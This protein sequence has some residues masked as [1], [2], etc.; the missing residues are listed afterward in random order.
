MQV[1]SCRCP[2]GLL[3][4]ASSAA[5]LGCKLVARSGRGGR[6]E[7]NTGTPPPPPPFLMAH[8]GESRMV[9]SPV[10][11]RAAQ[12]HRPVAAP[13]SVFNLE[14]PI[15]RGEAA[16]SISRGRGR[17]GSCCATEGRVGPP[18][19]PGCLD[20]A[21]SNHRRRRWCYSNTKRRDEN[22]GR[23]R[24]GDSE[25]LDGRGRGGL[26]LIRVEGAWRLGFVLC[27]GGENVMREDEG[28]GAICKRIDLTAVLT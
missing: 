1:E 26:W 12:L 9:Q 14:T 17:G 2:H 10:P 3:G 18:L 28:G 20:L 25:G 4:A 16:T 13:V 5:A 24:H 23:Q 11:P 8:A 19:E 27:T 15:S 21:G 22:K 7:A 6:W